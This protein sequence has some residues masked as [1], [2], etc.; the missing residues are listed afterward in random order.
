M[1]N[2]VAALYT[3]ILTILI[4]T[5]GEAQVT[6]VHV[7]PDTSLICEGDF[8]T[9]N[10]S[11][12]GPC[13]GSYEYQVLDGGMVVQAWSVIA[14][15]DASP[16]TSTTFTVELRC[17]SDPGTVVTNTFH[18]IV[19]REP[20]ITGNL[21]IC[22]G[23]S[24][25]LTASGNNGPFEWWDS[26]NGGNQLSPTDTWNTP[27]LNANTT[28][29]VQAS[30]VN[31]N[32]GVILIT[33]CGLEG[34]IGNA[35]ADYMEIS[36]LYNT[37]V[38]TTGWVAAISSSYVDI[39]AVNL[40][41]WHLPNSFDECSVVSRNDVF[42]DPNYWG[43]NIQW[44]PGNNATY[45]SWAI[46]IDDVGNVIDF[47]CWGWTAADLAGFNPTING[48]NITLGAEWIGDGVDSNCGT[49]GG[50]AYSIQRVGNSD[51]NNMGDFVCQ[52]STV[53]VVNPGLVCGWTSTV[54]RWP[55]TVTVNPNPTVATSATDALC[56]GTCTGQV[57]ALGATGTSPYTYDWG[58][59]GI[60]SPINNVC[61]G[62]YNLTVTDA[63][64]CTGTGS[65]V[66]NEPPPLTVGEAS[67]D[68]TCAGDN[69]GTITLTG[70][71]GTA[72]YNYDIGFGAPNGTGAFTN[73]PPGTYN[74]T[75]TD[76]NGCTVTGSIT[77]VVGPSCCPMTNTV[78]STNPL[79]A[80]ACDGTITLTENLGAPTV[81][82]SIDGGVTTQTSGNF[83]NV[84]AGTY[85]ILIEDGNGC[86]YIDVVTLT[87]PPALGGSITTQT[88]VSCNG[89][90]DGAVTVAGSG[91]T[92]PYMY[93]IGGGAQASGTFNGLCAGANNMTVSDANGCATTAVI[94]VNAPTTLTVN[95][96]N[97]TIIC[98]G[99]IAT[100]TSNGVGG[101][102]PY[103]Y[104]WND[105]NA[106]LGSTLN[107]G[108]AGTYT[109]TVT[110]ANGCMAQAS[111]IVAT[112]TAI[113]VTAQFDQ[114]ICS[115]ET[116]TISATGG[117]G[118]G[119]PYTYH[120]TNDDGSGWTASGASVSIS[121]T[122]TTTYTVTISD[123][124]GSTTTTDQV[125]VT[126][127][128]TPTVNFTV[129][130]TSGCTPVTAGFTNLTDPMLIGNCFWNFGDGNTSNDCNPTHTYQV[131]GCY[132][133]TLTVVSPD[134]CMND[135]TFT[136]LICVYEYPQADFVFGPQS[137]NIM[138]PV[139]NFSN[140]S[141][142]AVTYEWIFDQLGTSTDT[143]P[144]FTFPGDQPGNY[145]VCLVAANINNCMDTTCY[146]VMINDV[147]LVYVPN[148]FTPN[149]DGVN[150]YFVPVL[151]GI[152]PLS[153]QL[154]I[155]DRWGKLV[156]ESHHSNLQWGGAIGGNGET[157]QQG[158]YVWKL[159]VSDATT[160]KRHTF[161]GHVTLLR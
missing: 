54:C 107:I 57:S 41:P 47:V 117:G 75:V 134:G 77:I 112:N 43:N 152:D 44:N 61:A 79:C 55:V 63:N 131:P 73:L 66:V 65:I 90:C 70:G 39:N 101:T 97:D 19:V 160:S 76:A 85:N 10:F 74:Y 108:I 130:N 6:A 1:K 127:H 103:T 56:N 22:E 58:G 133:V 25:A 145:N 26:P 52:P 64:G 95:I 49:Q 111:V 104:A 126:V 109:V 53:D 51:N 146:S 98:D 88:D 143:N 81:T 93:D 114:T 14:S 48:F 7:A 18:V 24:T 144:S 68:E 142:D 4:S 100:I 139:V 15:Y 27:V 138:E 32:E 40:L 113:I 62:N 21:T 150:D 13:G 30:G 99:G 89:V 34:F 147:F 8:T 17:S 67:T 119:G 132:D 122:G 23:A 148:T 37:P 155:F 115:G 125:T 71:G 128:Q 46:I 120:W 59:L 31:S 118:S 11:S 38:N 141:T 3:V 29:Y 149:G 45:R 83:T 140:H 116:L 86:Q 123:G 82:Y 9:I 16:A 154:S 42:G 80:G 102:G 96:S 50:V 137:A 92:P 105:P 157:G 28:A 153:Y 78:A 2:V 36:N 159:E 33:E 156:F 136:Q 124:C 94:T 110:D 151:N 158:I 135:T 12:V 5:S 87:D 106:T 69:D 121:P 60:G 129:D 84:C 35:S 20:T 72:G 91:G 161:T